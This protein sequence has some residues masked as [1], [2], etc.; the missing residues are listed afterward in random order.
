[1]Y[2]IKFLFFRNIPFKVLTTQTEFNKDTKL[3]SSSQRDNVGQTGSVQGVHI[4]LSIKTNF[5]QPLSS[6]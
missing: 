5:K 3:L 4:R 6:P 2:L 1:M